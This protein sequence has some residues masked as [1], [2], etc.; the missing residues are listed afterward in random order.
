MIRTTTGPS[1]TVA[2]EWD[3]GPEAAA[4]DWFLGRRDPAWSRD[5]ESRFQQWLGADPVHHLAY[6]DAEALWADC[7]EVPRP[8]RVGVSDPAPAAAPVMKP[9]SG[10]TA[11]AWPGWARG[12]PVGLAACLLASAGGWYAWFQTPR[13]D[14]SVVTAPGETRQLTL[15]DGSLVD[16]NVGTDVRVRYFVGR[17]EVQ[18]NRG[19]AFFTVAPDAGRP[20]TVDSGRSRTTVTGTR[21]NLRADPGRLVVKVLDGQVR[22]Q[23]DR[24]TPA[25]Q[26]RPVILGPLQT[27]SVDAVS[28]RPE[29][30][31]VVAQDSVGDWRTG[32]L[33]FRR[34]PVTEMAA[35]IGRYLG[36]LVTVDG[37]PKVRQLTVSGFADTREPAAFLDALPDLLPVRVSRAVDGGY[38]IRGR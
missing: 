19:E 34:T 29:V 16:V 1:V 6:A 3:E 22:V 14:V 11:G 31:R 25:A 37:D 18:L 33:V 26:G 7:A 21:F 8:E 20:F 38:L 35:E 27:V 10:P 5:D 23:P 17:R 13:H 15:P 24:D 4:C 12:W 32:R 36:E 2:D 30:G 28:S 9:A